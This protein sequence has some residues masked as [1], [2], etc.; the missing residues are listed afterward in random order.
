M[1]SDMKF[2]PDPDTTPAQKMARF[3]NALRSVLR[4]SKDELKQ[5]MADDEKIR[6]RIKQKPGPKPGSS[7]SGHVADSET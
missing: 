5:R 2:D 7:V 1:E 3:Q 6:R 4:I